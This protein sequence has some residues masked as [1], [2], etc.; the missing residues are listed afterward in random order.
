MIFARTT[1]VLRIAPYLS[2]RFNV[3]YLLRQQALD[4]FSEP[5]ILRSVSVNLVRQRSQRYQR[6][7]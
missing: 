2:I 3:C 6:T 1:V 4:R 7:S 5:Q